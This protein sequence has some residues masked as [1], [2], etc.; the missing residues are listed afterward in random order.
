MH[1]HPQWCGPK[2]GLFC[3]GWGGWDESWRFTRWDTLVACRE[4]GL[5]GKNVSVGCCFGGRK[6]QRAIAG[7]GR[8]PSPGL[9]GGGPA[10]NADSAS[11]G[12][13]RPEIPHTLPPSTSPALPTLAPWEAWNPGSFSGQKRPHD[14]TATAMRDLNYE[15]RAALPIRR[16]RALVVGLVG[17]GMS[18]V[19]GPRARYSRLTCSQNRTL[20]K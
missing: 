9:G 20:N 10:Q 4:G 7:G 3:G 13:F 6:R 11:G 12:T 15:V 5:G 19:P 17:A 16:G 1:T 14:I 8:C 2:E 18:S